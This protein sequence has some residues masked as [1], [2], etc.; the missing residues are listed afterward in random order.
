[1]T[2]YNKTSQI[3]D[4]IPFIVYNNLMAFENGN[5]FSKN[6]LKDSIIQ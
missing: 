4:T 2:K 6:L 1:M 3:S 5:E